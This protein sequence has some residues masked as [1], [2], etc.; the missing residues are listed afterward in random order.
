MAAIL[1]RDCLAQVD[2]ACVVE[3]S[4]LGALRSGGSEDSNFICDLDD[5]RSALSA[6][7]FVGRLRDLTGFLLFVQNGI[8]KAKIVLVEIIR[9]FR[10]AS[11]AVGGKVER[12]AY[13]G[14]LE[15]AKALGHALELGNRC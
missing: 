14:Q 1:D 15:V 4:K 2:N 12:L 9:N 6:K 13:S 8:A 3:L 10:P 11:D 5:F 7:Y